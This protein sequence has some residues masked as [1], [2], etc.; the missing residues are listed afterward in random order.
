[1]F[2]SEKTLFLRVL[3]SKTGVSK[4]SYFTE[5]LE[6]VLF[7][8]FQKL[9]K[10]DVKIKF[11]VSWKT[12]S[13]SK[14]KLNVRFKVRNAGPYI[15]CTVKKKPGEFLQWDQGGKIIIVESL[16]TT[17]E[18]SLIFE[19]VGAEVKIGSR[20]KSYHQKQIKPSK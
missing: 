6:I 15:D 18:A 19:A 13:D 20:L 16:L 14:T 12:R 8:T 4:H 10:N 9:Q 7:R 1:M 11:R 17:F 2:L 3:G 5:N